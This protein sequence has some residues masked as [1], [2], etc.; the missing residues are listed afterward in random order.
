MRAMI[1]R[2]REV[3]QDVQGH[4]DESIR[5]ELICKYAPLV[6]YFTERF[7][8]RLPPHISKDKLESAGAMELFDAQLIT[9][10]VCYPG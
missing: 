3:T 9:V 5:E 4:S 6:K 8:V 10:A 7:A 2:Y 1:N